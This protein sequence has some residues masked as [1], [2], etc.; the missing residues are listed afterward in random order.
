MGVTPIL[1]YGNLAAQVFT[2]P[3][4]FLLFFL[5]TGADLR[6]GASR[7][8]L[9][10]AARSEVVWASRPYSNTEICRRKFSLGRLISFFFFLSTGADL[11]P[12]A[13]R[14]SMLFA[15]R[16]E[17]AWASRPYSNTEI[18]RRKFSLGRLISFFF[19]SLRAQT[20]DQALRVFRCFLQLGLRLY[21]RH[22]HTRIRKSV[23]TSFHLAG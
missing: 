15:P 10:F 6:P 2:W 13:S 23:G 5:S 17:V 8:S 9:L 11:R 22:A 14:L 4:D 18:W 3:A 1:E 19:S 21:G 7:L 16:S 20:S 12:G